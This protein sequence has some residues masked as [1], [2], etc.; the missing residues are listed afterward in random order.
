[1]VRSVC[2]RLCAGALVCSFASSEHMSGGKMSAR[3]AA[4]WPHFMNAG[5]ASSSVRLRAAIPDVCQ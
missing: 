2:A 3:V 5:P 4:H 1:M